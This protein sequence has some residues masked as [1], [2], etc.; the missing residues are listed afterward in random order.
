MADVEKTLQANITPFGLR[1]QPELK[2]RLEESAKGRGRSLNAE[3]V[4]RLEASF[5]HDDDLAHTISTHSLRLMEHDS[6]IEVHGDEIR[7]LAVRVEELA[8]WLSSITGPAPQPK[9]PGF[10]SRLGPAAKLA[11]FR[12]E[13]GY[14]EEILPDPRE[15]GDPQAFYDRVQSDIHASPEELQHEAQ[16]ALDQ[17]MEELFPSPAGWSAR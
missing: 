3:I 14:D 10:A 12:E 16:Q 5:E 11:A 9:D 4:A 7:A 6:S 2:A 8:R 13:Y 15:T 17:L 1:M